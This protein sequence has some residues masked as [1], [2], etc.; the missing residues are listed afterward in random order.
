MI[1]IP[2]ILEMIFYHLYYPIFH[3][4]FLL[5]CALVSR[6]W[7]SNALSFLWRKPFVHNKGENIRVKQIQQFRIFLSFLPDQLLNQVGLKNYSNKQKK[8][9]YNYLSYIKELYYIKLYESCLEFW[10]DEIIMRDEID[11]RNMEEYQTFE[12]TSNHPSEY[13]LQEKILPLINELYNLIILKY[14]AKIKYFEFSIPKKICSCNYIP[15]N[16]FKIS[17]NFSSE[18]FSALQSFKC[19]GRYNYPYKNLF[20]ELIKYSKNIM[21]IKFENFELLEENLD[22]MKKLIYSQKRLRNIEFEFLIKQDFSNLFDSLNE[23]KN[24]Q[25]IKIFYCSFNKLFPIKIL[26]LCK[27]LKKLSIESSEIG[28]DDDLIHYEINPFT[29]LKS[30]KIIKSKL[31][32][33]VF[34][35]LFSQGSNLERIIIREMD[36]LN[37]YSNIIPLI[38]LNCHQLKFLK[39]GL[40][41]KT[42]IYLLDILENCNKLQNLIIYDEHYEIEN[43]DYMNIFS[44]NLIIDHLSFGQVFRRMGKLINHNLKKLYFTSFYYFSEDEFDEFLINCKI[45]GILK[46]LSINICGDKENILT[47]LKN[48][49][50]A[51][52]KNLIIKKWE[53]K[54]Y[55]GKKERFYHIF[56]VEFT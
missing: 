56:V 37:K 45:N 7:S 11:C 47:L 23:K 22:Y 5:S 49:S 53:T 21:E 46:Y 48:Y 10:E 38:C 18:C 36:L 42:F 12:C 54:N 20:K 6:S 14:E 43:D 4:N 31:F 39:I 40:T 3:P 27:N 19:N 55:D 25:Y 44:S 17:Q 52:N 16:Y 8:F 1:V 50:N 9:N 26:S 41:E 35:Q 33:D 15:T 2:E 28:Y 30:L 34:N 32:K 51:I 13:F 29:K 24:L